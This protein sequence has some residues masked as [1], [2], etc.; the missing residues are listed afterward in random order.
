MAGSVDGRVGIDWSGALKLNAL[1]R[2]PTV[3]RR[4]ALL[5]EGGV[6]FHLNFEIGR[7]ATLDQLRERHDAVLIATGVYKARPLAV[8]GVAFT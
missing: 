1:V 3:E 5:A 8:P 7:D 2:S 4:H 6:V